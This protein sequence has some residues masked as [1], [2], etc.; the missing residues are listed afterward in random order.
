MGRDPVKE[1]SPEK[2]GQGVQKSRKII[3]SNEKED[4]ESQTKEK[5]KPHWNDCK[6]GTKARG[7]AGRKLRESKKVK[8]S[9]GAKSCGDL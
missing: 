4:L 3:A 2:E 6:G 8:P 9:R 5:L 7:K 1:E